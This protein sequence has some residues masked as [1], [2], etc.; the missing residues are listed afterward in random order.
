MTTCVR[1]MVWSF[2]ATTIL[3]SGNVL[4]NG[5]TSP[6]SVELVILK[7]TCESH[8]GGAAQDIYRARLVVG[9]N[10]I[11]SLTVRKGPAFV[12]FKLGEI[13]MLVFEDK[14]PDSEGFVP[15]ALFRQNG[16]RERVGVL[17]RYGSTPVRITGFAESRESLTVDLDRCRRLS[18][19]PS[20]SVL[21]DLEP[22]EKH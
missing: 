18:F 8:A 2:A 22:D 6:R 9:R 3:I 13:R 15:A 16:A 20:E 10:A 5:R 11:E 7:A 19:S 17:V 21:R 14:K 4:A 1:L 12:D